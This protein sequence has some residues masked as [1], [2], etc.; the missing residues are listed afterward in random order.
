MSWQQMHNTLGKFLRLSSYQ[1]FQLDSTCEAIC[2]GSYGHIPSLPQG[3]ACL[4][5]KKSS[6]GSA[7]CPGHTAGVEPVCTHCFHSCTAGSPHP[8][9]GW[10]A[11]LE[12]GRA[13]SFPTL[14]HQAHPGWLIRR[15][16]AP[17]VAACVLP[18]GA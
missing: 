7:F 10:I 6:P 18:P 11:N 13:C 4:P 16:C 2:S 14:Y 9:A 1:S 3:R 5:S 15:Q 17:E 12:L 8:H